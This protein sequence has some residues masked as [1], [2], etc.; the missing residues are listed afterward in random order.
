[1]ITAHKNVRI[2]LSL[3]KQY[4]IKHL[5]LS[6]G[7]RNMSI[8][9]SVEDDP[10]FTCYSVVDERSAAYFA[11]GLSL[12]VRSPVAITCT[13][14]QAT[15]NYIPGMT[16]AYYRK[17]PVLA[18]TTDYDD[19]F[20]S[21]LNMQSL[22]QMCVPA[23]AANV[24]LD[25][26]IVKDR[27]D[28]HLVTRRINEA[29]DALTRNGGGPAHLNVRINEHWLKGE[30]QLEPARKI[31]RYLPLDKEWPEIGKKKV[32]LVIGQHH[33]FYDLE[34]DAIESFA[35]RHDAAIYVNHI[36][37][38][39]GEK[40]VHGNF[41]LLTGSLEG[42]RPDLLI[43]M[44]G[45]L[46]DYPL[47]GNLKHAYVEHWRVSEDG[48]YSDA[49]NTVTKIFEC[50]ESFFFS[51]MA[52]SAS[53]NAGSK[54]FE[55]WLSA[56]KEIQI[57]EDLP[58]SNALVAKKLS[59]LIPPGSNM[60]FGILNSL[61]NW[62]LFNLDP[63]IKCYSNVAGFGIDGG[64]STFLGQSVASSRLNFLIIGDLSFFYDM[65][66]I[67]IRNLKNNIRIVLINN[68]GGCEF[69]LHIN[70][71]NQFGDD[72][73]RHIAA[74]G[75]FGESAEGWVRNNKFKYMSVKSKEEL[76]SAVEM[77]VEDSG[78]P[79]FMEVFTQMGDD[80]G[81]L[82]TLI[83]TNDRCS[84]SEKITRMI[85]ASMPAEMKKSL[86]RIIRG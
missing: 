40:S 61:R 86:K 43:T 50:P 5:V 47:D 17:A 63:S 84:H 76:D 70:A 78:S 3:L 56:T 77:L 33:P 24:S 6:P 8:V 31:T 46:G 32:L 80:S 2:L 51:R 23:D 79:I 4:K 1:M 68:H 75:H 69:R 26:P 42:I 59:P 30:D 20:T 44:G 11:V 36:S 14:A 29:L 12:E 49:Y 74:S 13:S 85:K 27:N 58:L 19:N 71:A 18:I 38:F 16:E 7:S 22:R 73:N 9:K 21:Q 53:E 15:R 67:G 10:F 82:K 39:N 83:D 28:E 35:R 66:A 48:N 57:P 52:D 41:V 62:E 64:V 55:K 45:H 25:L 65:N 34:T 37:N 72:S 81:A 54:Y 60:H